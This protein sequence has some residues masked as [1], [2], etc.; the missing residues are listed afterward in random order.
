[1]TPSRPQHR[2]ALDRILDL[3]RHQHP[4]CGVLLTGSL[5]RDDEHAASDIDLF[6]VTPDLKGFETGLGEVVFTNDHVKVVQTQTQGVP[7][8]ITCCDT[9]L[10]DTMVR[11]PWRNYLFAKARLLSDPQG[12]IHDAQE[13][14]ERWF[15]NHPAVERLWLQ[16]AHQHAQCKAAL[17]QGRNATLAFPSW[18]AFADHVDSLV[19][20]QDID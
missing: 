8:T 10:L 12:M 11:E 1:M 3:I 4:A 18:D 7:I 19:K 13:R 2:Q 17:R 20:R 6:A 16:Q 15:K 9:A 5:L 14:I